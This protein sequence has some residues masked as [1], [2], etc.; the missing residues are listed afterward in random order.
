MG[1]TRDL[2]TTITQHA[3]TPYWTAPEVFKDSGH[4]GIQA[5][6]YSF[7]IAIKLY[8]WCMQWYITPQA[9]CELC[10]LIDTKELIINYDK[11]LGCGTFGSVYMAEYKY[12]TVAVK[13]FKN[14]NSEDFQS[15]V[16]TMTQCQFPFVLSL[17]GI[18]AKTYMDGGDLRS[19][20]DKK[21]EKARTITNY[22]SL[23]IAWATAS[24]LVDVHHNGCIHRDLKSHNVLLST[25]NYITLS[26]LGLTR[27]FAT[28]MTQ[29]ADTLYWT[30]PEVLQESHYGFQSDIYSFGVLLTEL[31]TLDMPYSNLNL[32]GL[33]ILYKVSDGTLRPE[34][35]GKCAPWYKNLAEK[36]LANDPTQRPTEL[37]IIEII[38]AEMG[39]NSDI[40]LD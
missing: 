31:D 16:K 30:A 15:E 40:H 20:L 34:L 7:V 3:G 26:D 28:T 22:S 39:K 23:E 5:D 11:R 38:G 6:I 4:Y 37:G 13:T 9:K 8:E 36:C 2:R 19:H 27:D 10:S 18:S 33:S 24:S 25:K 12:N 21:H 1:L 14:Q 35:S 32:S 29:G 17:I